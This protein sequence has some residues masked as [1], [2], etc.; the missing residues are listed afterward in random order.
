MAYPGDL[1]KNVGVDTTV[2]EKATTF[3]TNTKLCHRMRPSTLTEGLQSTIK[4][5][6]LNTS[7]YFATPYYYLWGRGLNEHTDEELRRYFKFH[8][9]VKFR[10]HTVERVLSSLDKREPDSKRFIRPQSAHADLVF[11]LQP[12]HPRMLDMDFQTDKHKPRFKLLVRFGN[13]LNEHGLARVLIGVCGLHVDML[14]SNESSE[15]ELT[16]EG[17][18][19]T[20][21]IQLAAKI[22]CPRILEF[23]DIQPKWQDGMLA[24]WVLCNCSVCLISIRR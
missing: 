7:C 1:L 17:D 6:A 15:V 8:R 22:L 10:G 11:S 23:L 14:I 5:S 18:V 3:P 16:I 13:R 2:Q 24:C 9:D 12:I 4:K 21:D 19:T 20:D